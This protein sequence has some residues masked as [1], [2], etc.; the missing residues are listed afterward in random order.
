M[1]DETCINCLSAL[2]SSDACLPRKIPMPRYGL[3]LVQIPV[4]PDNRMGVSR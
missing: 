4:E 1:G 3:V 2:K